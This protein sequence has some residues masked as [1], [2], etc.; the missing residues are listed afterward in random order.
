MNEQ[1]K[2][3]FI[4][5]G[6]SGIGRAVAQRFAREGWH[7][8][9]ADV[10]AAGLTETAALLPEG[11][12]S[13]HIM[14]VRDRAAWEATLAEF[15]AIT[16]GRIDVLMNNAGI[17]V[18][19]PFAQTD[20]AELERIVAINLMGVVHGAH[21]GYR[22]LKATPGACLVNTASAAGIWGSANAAIYSATKAGV[23]GLSESLDAEW[24]KDGIRVACLMPSFIDT[25]LL[26]E[27]IILVGTGMG[28][29]SRHSNA[30]LPTLVAGGGFDHGRHI[31]IDASKPDAPLLGDLYITLMQQ[32]GVE[33][34]EFSN[35]NRNL[36]H[37]FS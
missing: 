37:I 3:I 6:G 32:L 17:A 15:T 19:G 28:D 31:A 12:A 2:A 30:D 29:A 4:T 34:N 23:R 22:H 18:S 14:D 5:G 13:T 26:D 33:T 35:A 7:V 36:N 16:G 25:P 24:A 10:N 1:A 20:P 8:G 9:L 27:T 21:V 11:K